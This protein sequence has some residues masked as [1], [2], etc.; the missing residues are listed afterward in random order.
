MCNINTTNGLFSIVDSCTVITDDNFLTEP[1]EFSK[2]QECLQ[3]TTAILR[4]KMDIGMV[5][6]PDDSF[7]LDEKLREGDKRLK[8][9]NKSLQKCREANRM[10]RKYYKM[11][12]MDKHHSLRE[13]AGENISIVRRIAENLVRFYH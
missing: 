12:L 2:F 3:T 5:V 9:Y 7:L 4:S 1:M 10:A 6:Y 8:K 11:K 13:F